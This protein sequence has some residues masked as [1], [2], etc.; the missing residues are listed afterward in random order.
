MHFVKF[1]TVSQMQNNVELITELLARPHLRPNDPNSSPDSPTPHARTHSSYYS[2]QHAFA[3]ALETPLTATPP[4]THLERPPAKNPETPVKRFHGEVVGKKGFLGM[5][6][7]KASEN[8]IPAEK[9]EMEE[10]GRDLIFSGDLSAYSRTPKQG[11]GKERKGS[12]NLDL[13]TLFRRGRKDSENNSGPEKMVRREAGLVKKRSMGWDEN[14]NFQFSLNL[15]SDD[16]QQPG[17]GPSL[18]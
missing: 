7:R 12:C 2:P 11:K 17:E 4:P 3:I 13:T 14:N 16:Q 9:R 15:N 5:K 8:N 1:N 6:A 18:T 10:E